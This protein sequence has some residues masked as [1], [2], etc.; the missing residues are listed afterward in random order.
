VPPLND[1]RPAVLVLLGCFQRGLEATGPNQSML[2]MAEKLA[3]RFRFSVVAEARPGDV[4]GQW[5]RLNGLEQLPLARGPAGARGLRQVLNRERYDLLMLNGFFDRQLTIPALAMRR[6]GLV[7][8]TPALLAPR[9][10]FSG[11]ALALGSAKKQSYL[12]LAQV[13]GLLDGLSL[14]AT[15]AEEAEKIRAGLPFPARILIGPNVRPLPALPPHS[16]RQAGAPLR[17]AFVGRVVPMKNLDFALRSLAHVRS[18]VEFN[19]YGPLDDPRYWR[20]CAAIAESL[21]SNIAVSQCGPIAQDAVL[22]VLA[23][24]DLFY[25]PSRGENYG[26][27]IVESLAA[28]TPILISDRTPWHVLAADRAGWDLPLDNPQAFATVIDQAAAFAPEDWALL[29]AGARARA[30]A[31]LG[32]D[33]AASQLARCIDEA[34]KWAPL[35]QRSS[36]ATD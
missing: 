35:T 29:R 3:D 2:G 18:A 13:A 27:A 32:G 8:R 25:L 19:L 10:E 9:G 33:E 24:H 17:V 30:E 28:G 5:T 20:E 7:P 4:P 15:T 26:H 34:M 36:G 6:A 16:P 1:E 22:N 23:G 14:Q 31:A 21:P 11:S 12:R